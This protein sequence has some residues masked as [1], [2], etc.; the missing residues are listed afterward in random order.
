MLLDLEDRQGSRTS[1]KSCRLSRAIR[2]TTIGRVCRARDLDSSG[3]SWHGLCSG[4][5]QDQP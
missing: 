1:Q 2:R 4:T 3:W 5:L